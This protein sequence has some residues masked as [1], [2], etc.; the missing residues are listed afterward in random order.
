MI[1]HGYH[2]IRGQMDHSM[3]DFGVAEKRKLDG[4]DLH[5]YAIFDGHSGRHVAQ[6][7][8]TH[9]LDNILTQPDLLKK[10]KRAVRRTYNITD[11]DILDNV[12][13]FRGGSTAVTVILVDGKKL[14]VANVGDSRAVMCRKGVAK[15][16]TVDHDPEAERDAVE[17]RGGCVIRRPGNV[18]RVDGQLAMSR[19]FGDGKVKEHISSEPDLKIVSVE[20]GDECD[21][22]IVASDGL[23]KVMSNQDACECIRDFVDPTDASKELVSEAVGRGSKDDISCIVVMFR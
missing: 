10:P 17:S 16:L 3:E 1:R 12:A 9:L 14:I 15:Q 19:A 4:H 6:Y 23:W 20:L 8:Q 21:F 13:G 18:D 2:L 5:L 7:L 11:H 22:L